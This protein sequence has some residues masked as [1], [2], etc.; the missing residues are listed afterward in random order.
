MK[1]F[2]FGLFLATSC[3][4]IDETK[5][6]TVGPSPTAKPNVPR[7]T[8][9]EIPGPKGEAGPSC[10]VKPVDGGTEITCGESVVVIPNAKNGVDGINGQDSTIAGPKGDPGIDGED[11]TVAGPQGV[12]GSNGVSC[13]SLPIQGGFKVTCGSNV[14]RYLIGGN[15]NIVYIP[16]NFE[17]SVVYSTSFNEP[18]IT[19]P[20]T[21]ALN[22]L[23]ANI[24]SGANGRISILLDGVSYCYQSSVGTKNFNYIGSTGNSTL[25]HSTSAVINA[26]S[27]RP[28]SFG[29]A[30][31]QISFEHRS[32]LS[33]RWQLTRSPAFYFTTAKEIVFN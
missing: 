23:A 27:V 25:C 8:V 29:V 13:S 30:L 22:A 33:T 18:F 24:S 4:H 28:V 2:L 10:V 15:P 16:K 19:L 11:S 21:F 6:I 12:A 9:V 32:D 7:A 26:A 3:G 20:A 31:V 17:S 1:K 5:S 14:S